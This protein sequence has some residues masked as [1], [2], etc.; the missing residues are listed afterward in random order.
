MCVYLTVS[1][2][3][4][5]PSSPLGLL[6]AAVQATTTSVMFLQRV[7]SRSSSS[8]VRPRSRSGWNHMFWKTSMTSL[9]MP[10]SSFTRR[11]ILTHISGIFS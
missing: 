1:K 3:V 7:T 11:M 10:S 9:R 6:E 4:S 2:S 8:M 5:N